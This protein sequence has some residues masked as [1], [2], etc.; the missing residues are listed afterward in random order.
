M[1]EIALLFIVVL[2]LFLPITIHVVEKNLEI[3]LLLM[4]ILSVSLT[5]V[6]GKESLWSGHLLREVFVEPVMITTAVVA[7][8]IVLF[9]LRP[10]MGSFIADIERFLG[11]RLFCFVLIILLGAISSVVTAIMSAILL[12]EVVSALRY[13]KE[14]ELKLVILSCFSIGLGAALTP[15]GEPLSTICIAKLKGEP[16]HAGFFFLLRNLGIFIFPGIG[17]LGLAGAIVSRSAKKGTRKDT[18]TEKER[19][20]I[21]QVFIYAGKVFIFI[22]ALILLGAGFK[23]MVDRY[24]VLL[25]KQILYWINTLSAVMDNA[26]LAAAEVS[27]QMST[28]QIRYILM[29]LLISGGMLIPGNIPNIIAA[30]RLGITSR[31]WAKWG[32]P[33]GL[34]LMTVYY[35]VFEVMQRPSY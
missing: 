9:F 8:G 2:V 14:F 22:M 10:R 12:V 1:L 24:I 17:A 19:E 18:L 15:I 23:P 4:G 32:I 21:G 25:P 31:E 13:D 30:G 26:T 16:Y 35:A 29:G 7:A 20:R 5:H 34:I 11:T 3:F 6:L 28:G 33:L 27:P